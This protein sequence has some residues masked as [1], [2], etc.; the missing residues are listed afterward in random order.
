MK[1]LLI[2]LIMISYYLKTSSIQEGLRDF[3][4]QIQKCLVGLERGENTTNSG[5]SV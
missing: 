3:S 5:V 2:D 4:Y 1:W